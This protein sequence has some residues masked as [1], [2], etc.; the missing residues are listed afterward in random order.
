MS[1][2]SVPVLEVLRD[3][4]NESL[5]RKPAS[6]PQVSGAATA[7]LTP[8]AAP[9]PLARGV[10]VAGTAVGSVKFGNGSTALSAASR[11]T[12]KRLAERHKERGGV[13]RIV[14]HAS[15]R[16]KDLP[17]ATHNLVNFRLSADRAQAVASELMR[18][19]V[20]AR[21]IIVEARSANDPIYYE[22]M[23]KGEAENRRVDIFFES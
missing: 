3:N 10:A 9:P 14:G 17:M 6:I 5:S 15:E 2:Q 20:P 16:T 22:W 4:Y 12:I 19:G 23:P 18:R 8:V 7:P 13:I 21:A 11:R 1:P